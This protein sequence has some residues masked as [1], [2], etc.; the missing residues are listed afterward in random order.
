M[1]DRGGVLTSQR[2]ELSLAHVEQRVPH[3]DSPMQVC[4]QGLH[5]GE[6]GHWG[7]WGLQPPLPTGL[8]LGVGG[9]SSRSGGVL[10]PTPCLPVSTGTQKVAA[11][12][13]P[14]AQRA[15]WKIY[16]LPKDIKQIG[17]IISE[18]W[19]WVIIYEC[20]TDHMVSH[21]GLGVMIFIITC[22]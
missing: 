11:N 8:G 22:V 4:V 9:T 3:R 15:C 16:F 2:R 17:N 19:S 6:P 10:R 14:R 21:A 7:V 20:I 12:L 5:W 18:S 1:V 13:F